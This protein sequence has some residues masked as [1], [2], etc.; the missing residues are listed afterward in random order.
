MDCSYFR[1][2]INNF[3]DGE[4]GYLEVAELQQHLS[5]CPDCAA[6]LAQMSEVRGALA[7]W[8]RLELTP[9]PGFA[10]RVTAAVELEQ[11]ADTAVP[12]GR[13]ASDALDKLDETL[14]RIP[15]PGGR[16][17]PVRNVIGWGLAAAAV[18]I[19]LERRHLRRTRELKPS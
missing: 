3:I 13:A 16:T 2:R 7:A 15:L 11:A 5:F 6:E 14:G 4:L 12:F 10:E 9:P 18:V 8:G 19:G 1:Q 17:I